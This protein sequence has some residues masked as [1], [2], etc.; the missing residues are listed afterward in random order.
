MSGDDLDESGL[1]RLANWN[2]D[3]LETELHQIL[4]PSAKELL[5]CLLQPK[6][7][8]RPLMKDVLEH[9]FFSS[10]EDV[11]AAGIGS[12]TQYRLSFA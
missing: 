4:D 2:A 1:T 11:S 12:A 5:K 6:K 8:D 10:R 3:S 7:E 9:P